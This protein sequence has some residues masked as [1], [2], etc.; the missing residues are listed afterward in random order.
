MNKSKYLFIR[1]KDTDIHYVVELTGKESEIN[2]NGK[3]EFVNV[4]STNSLTYNTKQM[5]TLD[6]NIF[7]KNYYPNVEVK[8]LTYEQAMAYAI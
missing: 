2:N 6:L 7:N 5:T 1:M 3:W 4:L 8:Y